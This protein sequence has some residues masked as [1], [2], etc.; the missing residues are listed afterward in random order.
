M[1]LIFVGLFVAIYLILGITFFVG[2]MRIPF[3]KANNE[4]LPTVSLLI[5]CRNEAHDIER[6]LSSIQD[7]KYPEHKLE[8]ILV[9]DFSTDSTP[10]LLKEFADKHNNVKFFSSNEFEETHLEAKARGISNAA[11]KASG[12]WLFIT[13]ADCSLPSTW[14]INM[15]DGVD[16]TT[17]IITGSMETL[18]PNFIGTLEKAVGLFKMF[19]GFGIAGFGFS[20]FGLG[21][22]MA[23]RRSVYEQAGG[24]E[25]ANFRIAE[26]MALF[27]MAHNLGY[28]AKYHLD[29]ETL[30]KVT[31]VDSLAQ[32]IS[33]QR[34]WLKG[35][36]E[37]DSS[38][39]YDWIIISVLF[40]FVAVFS[41]LFVYTCVFYPVYGLIF[42]LIKLS[43]EFLVYLGIKIRHQSKGILRLIPLTFV[44]SLV[45]YVWLPLS[46]IFKRDIAWMGDGYEVTYK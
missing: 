39:S 8:V 35:G 12:E 27:K 1:I 13:D 7:L 14:L 9:D 46:F 41:F 44:Y 37:G 42:S 25:K 36:F 11:K 4:P 2:M 24:L 34:R 29:K 38:T 3:S 26:D 10:E 30:V 6:C 18:S 15:L 45:T 21:P 31:P 40:I 43:A 32:L 19:I 16:D 33:Q 20:F 5:S 22:N 17:G 28:K 23:I